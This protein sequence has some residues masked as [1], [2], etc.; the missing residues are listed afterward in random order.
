MLAPRIANFDHREHLF[1]EWKL[2]GAS[3]TSLPEAASKPH[4][5]IVRLEIYEGGSSL[6][7]SQAGNTMGINKIC[8]VY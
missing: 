6:Q 4:L 3:L 7:P 1:L 2:D 8:I 5:S